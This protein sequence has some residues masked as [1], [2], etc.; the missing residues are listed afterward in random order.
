MLPPFSLLPN[1][2]PSTGVYS[3]FLA[4]PSSAGLSDIDGWAQSIA[5]C[6][7]HMSTEEVVPARVSMRNH[8]G[9]V[10]GWEAWYRWVAGAKDLTGQPMYSVMVCPKQ[11]VGK[12]THRLV[13]E[14]L[15]V[16]KPV[17]LLTADGLTPVVGVKVDED[18][19]LD[20]N[21]EPLNWASSWVL[22]LGAEPE[23]PGVW[24]DGAWKP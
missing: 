15:L 19:G 16:G 1:P 5:A 17:F 6:Y 3:I 20:E 7:P 21:G 22:C 13:E 24:E 4:H 12:R 11:W 18:A 14:F 8:L 10:G 23:A 2:R 9:L